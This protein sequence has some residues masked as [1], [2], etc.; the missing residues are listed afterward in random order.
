MAKKHIG[1]QY[2]SN[3]MS[4]H[5]NINEMKIE[6]TFNYA[7]NIYTKKVSNRDHRNEQRGADCGFGIGYFPSSRPALPEGNKCT[8]VAVRDNSQSKV[9]GIYFKNKELTPIEGKRDSD[10]DEEEETICQ[11]DPNRPGLRYK[12]TRKHRATYKEG[13]SVDQTSFGVGFS[14]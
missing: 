2:T 1:L 10:S 3:E 13:T 12:R 5:S 8:D 4:K 6:E 11:H 7:G 9:M 14:W